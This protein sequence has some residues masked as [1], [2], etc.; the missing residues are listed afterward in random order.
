MSDLRSPQCLLRL[1]QAVCQQLGACS[2]NSGDV[3]EHTGPPRLIWGQRY[4]F[5][6]GA[7]DAR[8]GRR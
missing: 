4:V 2:I 1:S 6:V 8:K 7:P 3:E 5:L